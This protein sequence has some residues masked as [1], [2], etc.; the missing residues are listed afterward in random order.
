MQ[1][2]T[3]IAAVGGA[4][5]VA[6]G[7]AIFLKGVVDRLLDSKLKVLEERRKRIAESLANAE[8]IKQQLADAEA[9]R[10]HGQ[11]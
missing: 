7:C 8:K 11:G 4:T 10:R 1:W 6:A 5:V 9:D 2:D 3:V